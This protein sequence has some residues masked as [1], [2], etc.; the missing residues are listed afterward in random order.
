M[1][2]ERE[3]DL[4]TGEVDGL[5]AGGKHD[6]LLNRLAALQIWLHW[7]KDGGELVKL[8]YV[9]INFDPANGM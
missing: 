1:C 2:D 8:S 5:G 3:I 7:S 6:I 4:R 9:V